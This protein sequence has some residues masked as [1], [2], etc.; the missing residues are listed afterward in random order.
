MGGQGLRSWSSHAGREADN[1]RT[2]KHIPGQLR[3]ERTDSGS[4]GPSPGVRLC[5]RSWG[6]PAE[7]GM[8]RGLRG[9]GHLG[10]PGTL[11]GTCTD[12]QLHRVAHAKAL[13]LGHCEPEELLPAST[14]HSCSTSCN[15]TQLFR[16]KKPEVIPAWAPTLPPKE[17]LPRP[18]Q[19][20]KGPPGRRH[21]LGTASA[22]RERRGRPACALRGCRSC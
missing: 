12:T 14:C 18:S 8:S 13:R 10:T 16:P 6:E 7:A 4:Q 11:C 21:P 17:P 5:T 19:V 3:G 22:G 1:K 9:R 20:Q 2:H 15:H